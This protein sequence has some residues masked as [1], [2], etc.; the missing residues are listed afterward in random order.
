MLSGEALTY[1]KSRLSE[2]QS[3]FGK[4]VTYAASLTEEVRAAMATPAGR[5]LE[6][7]HYCEER[8]IIRRSERVK[9]NHGIREREQWFLNAPPAVILAALKRVIPKGL[10]ESCRGAGCT[11]CKGFGFVPTDESLIHSDTLAYDWPAPWEAGAD[12]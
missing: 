10:C 1:F 3:R 11:A 6:I 5:L 12:E 2:A 8:I 9:T 7:I 4:A